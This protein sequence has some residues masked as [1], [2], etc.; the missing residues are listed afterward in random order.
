MIARNIAEVEI[1]RYYC[2]R[3][4]IGHFIYYD[5]YNTCSDQFAEHMFCMQAHTSH[6][7]NAVFVIMK[8][9]EVDKWCWELF[10]KPTPH[11]EFGVL[12]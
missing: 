12:S 9:Y 10:L 1:A 2:K 8:N 4:N 6:L 3:D 11:I 5:L 7:V